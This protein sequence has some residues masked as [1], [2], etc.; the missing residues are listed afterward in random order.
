MT[1][2]VEKWDD[3]KLEELRVIFQNRE[4]GE[5]DYVVALEQEVLRLQKALK[6]EK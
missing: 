6:E 1:D 5:D 3:P 4:W 2:W